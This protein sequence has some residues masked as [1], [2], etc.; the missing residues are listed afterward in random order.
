MGAG[1]QAQ[2]VILIQTRNPIM[3]LYVLPTS[4]FADISLSLMLP[5]P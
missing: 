3:Y 4:M 5:P 1:S 2:P